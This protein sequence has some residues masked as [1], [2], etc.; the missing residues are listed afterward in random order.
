MKNRA[1]LFVRMS[2]ELRQRM[3]IIAFRSGN[4]AHR[5]ARSATVRDDVLTLPHDKADRLH[6][7]SAVFTPV[8][9]MHINMPAPE[10]GRTMVCVAVAFHPRSATAAGEIFRAALEPLL[11]AHCEKYVEI[12]SRAWLHATY[13]G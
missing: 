7:A 3:N 8:A 5:P 12:A 2:G 10:T 11:L 4:A 6:H 9:R 13:F 1:I